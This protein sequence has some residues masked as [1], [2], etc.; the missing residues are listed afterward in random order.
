[1]RITRVW[2]DA[3]GVSH[4][5]E[6]EV[7]LQEGGEIGRLSELQP[8]TGVAVYSSPDEG[9][10]GGRVTQAMA[11]AWRRGM[12]TTGTIASAP[13]S[14]RWK[15]SAETRARV[16]QKEPRRVSQRRRSRFMLPPNI[17]NVAGGG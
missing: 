12:T 14:A 8:A 7:P 9:A 1:M 17:R 16:S 13:R 5:E 3:E 6:V 15:S 10:P 2:E 11:S 4:F